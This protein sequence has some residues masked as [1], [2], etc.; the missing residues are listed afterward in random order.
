MSDRYNCSFSTF[1]CGEKTA[2]VEIVQG[3][4]KTTAYTEDKTKLPFGFLSDVS[5]GKH[6]IDLFW[7]SR[8][9]PRHKADYNELM[10]LVGLTE[11]DTYEIVRRTNGMLLGDDMRI[12]FSE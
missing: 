12:D 3:I 4:V 6:Q 1:W 11:Y 9:F 2:G 8:S 10:G 7:E 5:V